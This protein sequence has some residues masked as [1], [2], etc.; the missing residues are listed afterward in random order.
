MTVSIVIPCFNH[1]RFVG[2]AIDSALAQSWPDVDVVV[3]DDG[4]TDDSA[5]IARRYRD[6]RLVRQANLGLAHAR[7]AGLHTTR[8]DIV[9]FL[10][11]DD[12]LS[13]DAARA[14]SAAL[15]DAPDA[16]MAVGRCRLIDEQGRPMPTDLPH[17]N[18]DHF[19][20]LLRRNYI[21]MPAMAAYR[22]AVFRR[23]GH[24]D[25]RVDPSADYDM[26]LRVARMWPVAAHTTTVADYR[27]HGANMS[28]NP[29]LMLDA[30]LC[31][32]RR[33]RAFV[34]HDARLMAAYRDGLRRWR[35]F[36]GERLVDRFRESLHARRWWRAALD[37]MHLLR[38]YPRG[39]RRHIW[40]KARLAALRRRR[41]AGGGDLLRETP[42]L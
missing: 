10:D 19:Q 31:V 12:R 25:P 28:R 5:A 14:A 6:V 22:R 42:R 26:Y 9:I 37:A 36:Y 8:G 30:T 16:M 35:E 34:R 33:Q 3:V 39:V 38:L 21:W 24:F 27:Q 11:A 13:P 7:N 4:S 17:V 2:E 18:T 41:A 23:V 20:E 32:V 15:H 40:K 1:A 29:V